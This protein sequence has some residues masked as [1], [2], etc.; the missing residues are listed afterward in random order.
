VSWHGPGM[1]TREDAVL[2]VLGEIL[3]S[4]KNSRLYKSLVYD[5]QS[6]QSVSAGANAYELSGLFQIIVTAKPEKGLSD[7][8]ADVSAI[9]NDVLANSVTAEEIA[10]AT[11][12]IED[13]IV[14]SLSTVLG[15]ANSLASYYLYTGDP[16]RINKE[17][18][19]YAGIT[20]EEIKQVAAKYLKNPAMY[21]S[22]VPEGKI[23]LAF[24][25][26]P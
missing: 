17:M 7:L 21:L 15:K 16:G 18:E 14:N 25:K 8:G 13:G 19:L 12:G 10:R 2:T 22:V 26:A 6:A 23:E 20:P 9:V 5:K 4:G 3:S 24:Q 1:N 11:A